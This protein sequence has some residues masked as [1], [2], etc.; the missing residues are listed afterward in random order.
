MKISVIIP[1]F[2]EEKYI[3]SCLKSLYLQDQKANEI[4]I[5]DNNCTDRTINIAKKF[6]NI[7]IIKET[8]QGMTPARNKGF[9]QAKGDIFIKCDA[10]TEFPNNFISEIKKAFSISKTSVGLTTPVYFGD[11]IGARKM[12]WLFFLYLYIPKLIIGDYPLNG[13]G[14]AITKKVWKKVKNKI[15]LDDSK[16]HEDIDLSFHIKKYG[17]IYFLKHVFIKS[18]GRRI[19]NNP[20]SFFGEYLSRFIKMLPSHW[21]SNIF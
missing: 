7:K 6:K 18:S 16:V 1:V 19:I 5:I 3:N 12:P 9:N 4:I 13:P 15:C 8:T 14:Y 10:D 21:L 20:S 2:N 17:R 11:L